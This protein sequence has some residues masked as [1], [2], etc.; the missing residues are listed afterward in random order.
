MFDAQ[1]IQM[2][3]D[4]TVITIGV[5]L[6][7]TLISYVIGIPLGVF[8]ITSAKDG[9]QPMPAVNWLVGGVVNVLRSVPFLILFIAITPLTRAVVQ[10]TIGPKAMTFGLVVSAA[11]F[12][13]RLVEQ[14]LLEVDG[15]VIEAA[16]SMGA[17]NGQI[18]RKV[19]LVEAVPSLVTGSL[20]AA[21]TILGYSAMA[22]FVGGGG[23]GDVAIKYG[24]YRYENV[25]MIITVV[26]L[27][28]LVQ[29]IQSVGMRIVKKSDKRSKDAA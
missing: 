25:T 19:L 28:L 26:I 23:L 1:Y 2:L 12:V 29:V 4:N 7:T 27:V 15:G 20:V 16:Q 17:S 24:Y 8:L 18:V 21:T 11:P 13:A 10:T 3:W 9:I 22:G 14:S 5:T 6:A